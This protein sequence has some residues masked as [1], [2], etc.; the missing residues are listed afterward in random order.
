MFFFFMDEWYLVTMHTKI[1][2]P[3]FKF[4]GSKRERHLTIGKY[5]YISL[6]QSAKFPEIAQN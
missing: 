5:M 2:L 1:Y 6:S 4:N 3:Q